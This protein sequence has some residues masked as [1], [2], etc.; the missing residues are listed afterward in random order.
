M[1]SRAMKRMKKI[2]SSKAHQRPSPILLDPGRR[3]N[4]K[5]EKKWIFWLHY[6]VNSCLNLFMFSHQK[7]WRSRKRRW[8][9]REAAHTQWQFSLWLELACPSFL[10]DPNGSSRCS[11]AVQWASSTAGTSRLLTLQ[12]QCQWSYPLCHSLGGWLCRRFYLVC[13]SASRC[14]PMTAGFWL[15]RCSWADL[16]THPL[17]WLVNR[18]LSRTQ[19]EHLPSSCCS[20]PQRGSSQSRG[21][22]PQVGNAK[23]VHTGLP[24]DKEGDQLVSFKSRKAWFSQK[25]SHFFP[26]EELFQTFCSEAVLRFGTIWFIWFY[27]TFTMDTYEH[28][29]HCVSSDWLSAFHSCIC[30]S[31]SVISQLIGYQLTS[32]IQS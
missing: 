5:K 22:R 8:W 1:T 18:R 28:V 26:E 25:R 14:H 9:W 31:G 12:L 10:G 7:W 15:H 6:T 27:L 19:P 24:V 20:A 17:R 4:K 2:N 29:E 3:G 30:T 16:H 21:C 11:S 32:N 13:L 23:G